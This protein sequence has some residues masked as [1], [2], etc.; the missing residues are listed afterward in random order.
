MT[1]EAV[2]RKVGKDRAT[3]AN[4]LRLLKLPRAAQEDVVAGRLTMGHAR[5]LLG[6]ESDKD[7]DH[8]RREIVQKD[9]NVRQTESRVKALNAHKTAGRAKGA[10]A[11]KNIFLDNL[12][13]EMER[14]LGT[15]V[16]ILPGKKGGKVVVTY[17]SDDD[18]DRIRGMIVSQ[19]G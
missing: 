19:I 6:L 15:K 9:L 5:A 18:L 10:A 13:L 2:A 16:E 4:F 14:S 11:K 8:L 7:L 12:E 1:Q 17:Y 3:V